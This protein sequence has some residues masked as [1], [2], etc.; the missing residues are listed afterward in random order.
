MSWQSGHHD[1]CRASRH[2]RFMYKLR[3]TQAMACPCYVSAP[4]ELAWSATLAPYL[5]TPSCTGTLT[6]C[7]LQKGKCFLPKETL[8]TAG[9]RVRPTVPLPP[10]NVFCAK[11]CKPPQGHALR[12]LASEYTKGVESCGGLNENGPHQL[13]YLV[14]G[15]RLAD[16]FG[17][18]WEVWRQG[19]LVTGGGL[20]DVKAPSSQ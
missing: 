1:R 4:S 18:D 3:R 9:W 10:V 5:Q 15:P 6:A 8:D 7:F 11:N 2:W 14:L 13:R 20:E 17:K 16:L 19:R 12:G